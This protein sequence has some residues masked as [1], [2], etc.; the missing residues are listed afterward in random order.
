MAAEWLDLP[1]EPSRAAEVITK[2]A[3]NG[4][5]ALGEA[6]K[7]IDDPRHNTMDWETWHESDVFRAEVERLLRK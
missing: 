7:P 6:I 1:R 2:C 3:V 5:A 4:W